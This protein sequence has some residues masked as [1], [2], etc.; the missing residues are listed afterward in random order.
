M[1]VGTVGVDEAIKCIDIRCY[2]IIH[3]LIISSNVRFCPTGPSCS[4][5]G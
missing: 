1:V 5:A 3:D 2:S 4:N